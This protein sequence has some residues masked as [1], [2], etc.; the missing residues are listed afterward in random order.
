MV[1]SYF[2]A[3][4]H[5]HPSAHIRKPFP[6][7]PPQWTGPSTAV[8]PQVLRWA[9]L[10]GLSLEVTSSS[11]HRCRSPV[12]G[13][14]AQG[15]QMG[16]SPSSGLEEAGKVGSQTQACVSLAPHFWGPHQGQISYPSTLVVAGNGSGAQ[17][18]GDIGASC[19][20]LH[21]GAHTLP[22]PVP[23]SPRPCMVSVNHR[24]GRGQAIP[25]P[26]RR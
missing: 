20:C 1:P 10:Y 25:V 16:P 15:A 9:A 5:P 3:S 13:F 18:L 7:T 23:G 14:P 19:H 12:G 22:D 26:E 21:S 2:S 11:A 4:K 6:R 24:H 8:G 17:R